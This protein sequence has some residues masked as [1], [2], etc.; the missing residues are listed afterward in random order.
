MKHHWNNTVNSYWVE[1][2]SNQQIQGTALWND[3]TITIRSHTNWYFLLG[4][5]EGQCLRP[6]DVDDTATAQDMDYTCLCKNWPGHAPKIM[7][8]SVI[9][10]S[11]SLGKLWCWH[12]TLLVSINFFSSPSRQFVLLK[13]RMNML[14]TWYKDQIQ[15]TT[16]RGL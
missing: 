4:V 12:W 13:Y 14:Y 2:V 6:F 1:L 11:N 7:A 15:T 3:P 16:Y 10:I 8:R 5:C 9:F